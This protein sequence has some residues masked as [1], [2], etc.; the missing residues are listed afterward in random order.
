MW[1]L[2]PLINFYLNWGFAKNFGLLLEADA[3]TAPQSRAEDI[4]A[5]FL[6][7]PGDRLALK[8]GYRL[9]EGGSDNDEVYNF[10]WFNYLTGVV[11]CRW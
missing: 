8:A 6:Y 4:F 1:V 11:V 7:Q 9:L 5:G 2:M 3:L 10:T